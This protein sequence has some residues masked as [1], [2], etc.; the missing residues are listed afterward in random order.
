MR[1]FLQSWHGCVIFLLQCLLLPF[2]SSNTLFRWLKLPLTPNTLL[3]FF[4]LLSYFLPRLCMSHNG[5]KPNN[6]LDS[7]LKDSF[8]SVVRG[9]FYYFSS[10]IL[11][12]RQL[13]RSQ[14]FRTKSSRYKILVICDR[15]CAQHTAKFKLL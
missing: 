11:P 14:T 9:H 13:Q 6:N 5:E 4:L 8:Y 7:K 1:E 10:L 2:F 3:L 15:N 12:F